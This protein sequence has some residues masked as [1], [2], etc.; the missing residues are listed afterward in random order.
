MP[1]VEFTSLR[2]DQIAVTYGKTPVVNGS[3]VDYADWPLYEGPFMH[4]ER[5][6]EKLLMTYGEQERLLDFRTLTIQDHVR[7]Q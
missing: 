7:K 2:G 3:P 6:S 5:G 4:A 1:S